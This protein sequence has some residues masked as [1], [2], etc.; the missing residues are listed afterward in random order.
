LGLCSMLSLEWGGGCC[1]NFDYF[2][3]RV[4]N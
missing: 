3:P 4:D 2:L 1:V